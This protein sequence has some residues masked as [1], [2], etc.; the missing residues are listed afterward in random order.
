MIVVI[1]VHISADSYLTDLFSDAYRM[2]LVGARISLYLHMGA[3]CTVT[4]RLGCWYFP[5]TSFVCRVRCVCEPPLVVSCCQF[6]AC[7][8]LSL[9]PWL[10]LLLLW[11]SIGMQ[12]CTAL[13]QHRFTLILYA[14][15]MQHVYWCPYQSIIHMFR[16]FIPMHS[17]PTKT[18]FR[19]HSQ[20]T[21]AVVPYSFLY[22]YRFSHRKCSYQLP[23]DYTGI[24]DVWCLPS[25]WSL[26]LNWIGFFF[27]LFLYVVMNLEWKG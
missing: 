1:V 8:V 11:Y 16:Y 19:F 14:V 3:Q 13:N 23:W 20:S 22:L 21:D 25:W 26:S 9:F 12:R 10:T 2:R 5:L 7:F 27:F 24:Y 6:I 4:I 18:W 15:W 17:I